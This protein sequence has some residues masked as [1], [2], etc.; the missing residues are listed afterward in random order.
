MSLQAGEVWE[1]SRRVFVNLAGCGLLRRFPTH[2][3][4]RGPLLSTSTSP[5]GLRGFA[6]HDTALGL[7]LALSLIHI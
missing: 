4:V 7:D 3:F 1:N 6:G 2:Q 5:G